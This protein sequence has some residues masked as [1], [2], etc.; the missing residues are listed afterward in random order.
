MELIEKLS[1]FLLTSQAFWL[2]RY[3]TL[4][5]SANFKKIEI[6]LDAG[7]GQGIVSL[8]LAKKGLKVIAVDGSLDKIKQAKELAKNFDSRGNQYFVVSDLRNLA[9][10]D[11]RFDR[12]VSLDTLE[13][14]NEDQGVFREFFR[15]LKPIGR[16]MITVPQGYAC[17]ARLFI[18]QRVLRKLV[19]DF[20]LSKDLPGNKSWLRIDENCFM[21]KMGDVQRYTLALIKERTE[22]LFDISKFSYFLKMFSSLAMDIAYGIKGM[23]RLKFLFFSICVR[24]DY[25]FQKNLPGYGLFVELVKKEH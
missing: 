18:C 6:V 8:A 25:Y 12:I 10:Q 23:H 5:K 20:L 7:C 1:K 15:V 17:S 2:P 9:L 4:L 24:L 14:I 3:F 19:P 16:L 22:I 11:N 13:F 21:E